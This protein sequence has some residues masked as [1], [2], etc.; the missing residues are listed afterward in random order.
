MRRASL[1]LA[2]L[3]PIA[4]PAASCAAD[5]AAVPE[6]VICGPH[7]RA[8]A[9]WMAAVS[10]GRLPREGVTVV[11]ID[12]HPDLS[13]PS[14]PFPR[15]FRDDAGAVLAHTHIANFQLAAVRMGFVDEIVWLRP[16]WAETFPDGPRTFQMGTL[17]SGDLAV[18]DPS[19][20]YVLDQGYAPTAALR[21]PQPV[22]FRVMPL[23]AAATGLLAASPVIL[24]IDLDVF[25][26]RNPYADRLRGA[27]ISD[28][29][30]DALRSIF[31]PD[32]L[33][34][35]ADPSTRVAEVQALTDA[36]AALANGRWMAVPAALVVFWQRGIGP[37]DLWALYGIV[38]RA[39]SSPTSLEA[40]LEDARQVIGLP[41]RR[42]DPAEIAATAQQIRALLE[43]GALR[44][45]LVTIA[46]SVRDGFTP[47]D[48]WPLIEW[49][50]LR[51][52][53][54]VLPPETV[55]RFDVGEGPAPRLAGPIAP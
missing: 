33:G 23:D 2:V 8:L 27:G 17:V 25:A 50:L 42:A 34:L 40:L 31:A 26:T 48:A 29:D 19:D 30:L 28:A 16:R 3:A 53:Q 20:H 47:R 1:L 12:A 10:D 4:L 46:R 52:L 32:G 36:V 55:I 9:H 7:D 21:D 39:S 18:D 24:D 51:E 43:T 14:A 11:H 6:V 38:D 49:S 37:A 22:Q 54:A 5:A 41:E 13:L 35:A 45:A 15:G 44:P